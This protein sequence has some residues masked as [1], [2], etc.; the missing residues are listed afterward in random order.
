MNR[1][2]VWVFTLLVVI[3]AALAHLQHSLALR[4][5]AMANLDARLAAATAQVGS[6]LRNMAREAGAAAAFTARDEK[7][8]AALNA[9]ETPAMKMRR[10]K[11]A[12]DADAEEAALRDAAR[13]ALNGVER[14]FGFELP[15]TTVV[16]AGNREWLARKGPPSVAEGEGMTFLRAAIDGK[17]RRGFVRLSRKLWYAAA[18]PAGAGAG[19]MVLVPI[20]ETWAKDVASAA[21]TDVTV[22][23]PDVKPVTT[24]GAADA[25]DLAGTRL[26][27]G[28]AGDLGRFGKASFAIGPVTVPALPLL[29]GKAPAARARAFALEGVDKG[30]VV[31]SAPA[32]KALS[33]IVRM[34]WVGLAALALVL[35]VGL[36]LGFTVRAAEVPPT[37]PEVLVSAAARIEKG[38]F[39][40]RVP[41]FAG[42]L[43]T[44]AA[45]LNKAAELAGPA[46]AGGGR[47]L[48]DEPSA[49]A[50]A[51]KAASALGGGPFEAAPARAAAPELLK[52]AAAAAPPSAAEV[53]AHWQEIYQEFLRTRAQ[54]G[55]ASEGLTYEKFKVKLEG[56][57]AQLISKYACRSVRFQVY[58]KEGKA[59]LKA[60]PVK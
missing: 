53:D 42:K 51:A 32:G 28:A 47:P 43:G 49:R 27:P 58:V 18:S 40:A 52:G 30:F 24:A 26:V 14:T 36:V 46:A 39:A 29:T 35:L 19:L 12:V 34:E 41:A 2:K 15:G 17:I 11:G 4:A 7:L 56:N 44:V 31:V 6:S 45:A 13:A 33:G 1:I 5:G 54:C 55:E 21:G 48:S 37:L 38:D 25:L 59:A 16:T 22:S 20:D 57:K 23:V 50:P 60:T 8:V 9:K 3:A 10:A